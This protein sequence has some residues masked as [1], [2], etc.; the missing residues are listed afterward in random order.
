MAGGVAAAPFVLG[1]RAAAGTARAAALPVSQRFDLTQPSHDLFRNMPLHDQ[2]V[3]QS[4]AYDNVNRRLFTAQLKNGSGSD[5]AGDLCITQL[6][7]SGNQLGFMFLEG[8]GHGVSIGA[9]PVGTATFLWTEVDAPNNGPGTSARGVRLARFKFTS[10]TTL[11]AASS[12][13]QKHTPIA[14]VTTTTPAIDPVNERLVMRY[15]TGGTFR[16]AVYDL[17]DVNAG[18]YTP[19]VDI[20]QPAGLGTF[21][22][23][24]IYGEF[25]YTIDGTAYDTS[26]PAPGNTFVT[27]VDLNT[28]AVVDREFTQAGSTLSYREP[29]GLAI[30]RTAAGE[31]RLFLGFASGE[32]GGRMANLFYKNVLV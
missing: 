12:A 30:Y 11:T 9:E 28:G 22:G 25:L 6:D 27:C 17:A 21:Q 13:L 1:G 24:T 15:A 19:L 32:S 3:M 2:T 10:G 29:E 8:F 7:F 16:Y 18:D 26:N 31:T 20:A 5:A 4:F 23:Y 14:G